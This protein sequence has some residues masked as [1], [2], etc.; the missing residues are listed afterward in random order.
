MSGDRCPQR[1]REPLGGCAMREALHHL[2]GAADL[3]GYLA[4]G[5]VLVTFSARSITALRSMAIASNVMFIA[6][7]LVAQLPPVLI[8]HVLLLPLNAWRLWQAFALRRLCGP[9]RAR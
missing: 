9:Q 5:L 8:L 3:L 4:A 7:A 1:P 2:F 6:Y